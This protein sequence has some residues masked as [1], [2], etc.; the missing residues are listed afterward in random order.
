MPRDAPYR[1]ESLSAARWN[2]RCTLRFCCTATCFLTRDGNYPVLV[3]LAV[4]VKRSA[5]GTGAT[6]MNAPR[7]D[8]ALRR[9]VAQRINQFFTGW[10]AQL[11]AGSAAL[12]EQVENRLAARPKADDA[13]P[14]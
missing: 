13:A 3:E 7:D 11:S 4:K 2:A 5:A 9:I 12:L 6:Q 8:I 10:I 1:A 14:D